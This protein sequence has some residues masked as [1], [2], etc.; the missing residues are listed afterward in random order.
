MRDSF[1]VLAI[2]D[3]VLDQAVVI[4]QG[5]FSHRKLQPKYAPILKITQV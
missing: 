2:I 4:S 3:Q 1:I 5:N